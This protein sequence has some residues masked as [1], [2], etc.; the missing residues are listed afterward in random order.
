MGH[1]SI[2][3]TEGTCGH[4]V[5]EHH[6][7]DVDALEVALRPIQRDGDAGGTDD[8]D[9]ARPARPNTSHSHRPER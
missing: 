2:E 6:E 8:V 4:L 9:V 5:R 3:E 7:R 1:A